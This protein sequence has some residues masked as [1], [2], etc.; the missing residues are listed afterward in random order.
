[1]TAYIYALQLYGYSYFPLADEERMHAQKTAVS[2]AA[3]KKQRN[4][5]TSP[6]Y[7]SSILSHP[8]TL[9]QLLVGADINPPERMAG[10][11]RIR[12]DIHTQQHT[13][14]DFKASIRFR[15]SRKSDFDIWY[16]KA[17][18]WWCGEALQKTHRVY[19]PDIISSV[20]LLYSPICTR[21]YIP[22]DARSEFRSAAPILR[23]GPT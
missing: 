10:G 16:T 17:T 4:R 18:S 6:L 3:R 22:S 7:N 9:G 21:P 2:S 19:V 15:K 8:R 5:E 1:M 20:I 14:N 13:N 12:K 11:N 23:Q